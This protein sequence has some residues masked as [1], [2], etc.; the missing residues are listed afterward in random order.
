[1]VAMKPGKWLVVLAVVLA[2]LVA[3][4]RAA[5]AQAK[6]PWL[7]AATAGGFL[8]GEVQMTVSA[9]METIPGQGTNYVPDQVRSD[10]FDVTCEFSRKAD[11]N[12]Y[13]LSIMVKTMSNVSKDYAGYLASCTGPTV[14]LKGIGNEAVQCVSKN[15]NGE[16]EVI[17]RVRNRAFVLTVHRAATT[18][19]AA[20]ELRADTHNMAEQVA[21]SI[22]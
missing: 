12:T 13:T 11:A 10:R 17:S 7:N 5:S 22:F 4:Q 16:E 6:C 21:G 15:G 1:M 2:G 9:P 18:E 14:P 20:D 8:G 3:G 19:G